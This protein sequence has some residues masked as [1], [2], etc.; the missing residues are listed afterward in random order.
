M[1]MMMMMMMMVLGKLIQGI[2]GNEVK[3]EFERKKGLKG[4]EAK[5]P[6]GPTPRT[7][8]AA[9]QCSGMLDVRYR[10]AREN[11]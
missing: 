9:S 11:R 10:S 5:T 8:L 1:M 3:K 7:G 4:M 2:E 6:R